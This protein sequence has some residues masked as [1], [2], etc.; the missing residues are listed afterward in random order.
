[1]VLMFSNKCH[2]LTDLLFSLR[3]DFVQN[4][5]TSVLEAARNNYVGIVELLCETGADVNIKNNVSARVF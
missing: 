3:I 2:S 1:M 4:G 5:Y